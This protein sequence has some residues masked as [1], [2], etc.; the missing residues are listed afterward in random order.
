MCGISGFCNFDQD[1]REKK[2]FWENHLTLMQQ[3]RKSV[4]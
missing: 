3:D 4:V 2:S 1:Y